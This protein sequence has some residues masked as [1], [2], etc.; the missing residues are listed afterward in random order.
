MGGIGLCDISI[1]SEQFFSIFCRYLAKLLIYDHFVSSYEQEFF[2]ISGFLPTIIFSK[3]VPSSQKNR[4]FAYGSGLCGIFIISS[5]FREGRDGCLVWRSRNVIFVKVE[6]NIH[7][8]IE[9]SYEL[10]HACNLTQIF[11]TL[12][13]LAIKRVSFLNLCHFCHSKWIKYI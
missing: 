3:I 5:V 8:M 1:T 9:L 11:S 10:V 6:W 4:N 7:I 2:S 12:A 13:S